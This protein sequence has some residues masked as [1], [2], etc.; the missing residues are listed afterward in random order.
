MQ[1]PANGVAMCPRCSR[2]RLPC[3]HCLFRGYSILKRSLWTQGYQ[4]QNIRTRLDTWPIGSTVL[5]IYLHFFLVYV[6]RYKYTSPIDPMVV[7][8]MP[9]QK[10]GTVPFNLTSAQGVLSFELWNREDPVPGEKKTKTYTWIFR[11]FFLRCCFSGISFFV[12]TFRGSY[13]T[14]HLEKSEI[15]LLKP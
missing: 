9:W 2:D 13:R 4:T 15:K 1:I 6:Y 12:E 5:V 11:F 7:K 10:F 8:V 3:V 14:S